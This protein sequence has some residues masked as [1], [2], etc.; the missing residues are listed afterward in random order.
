MIV[1]TKLDGKQILINEQHIETAY[2]TPDTIIQMNNGHTYIV[3]ES[4]S[5]IMKKT[6]EFRRQTRRRAMNNE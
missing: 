6:V 2:E 3:A 4:L 1:L 5:E